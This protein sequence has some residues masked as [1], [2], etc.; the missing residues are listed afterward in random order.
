MNTNRETDPW[1]KLLA[2]KLSEQ[3]TRATRLRRYVTG[4]APMPS[5]GPNLESEWNRFRRTALTNSGGLVVDALAERIVATGATLEGE[6]HV[7]LRRI[8]RDNRLDVTITDAIRDALTTGVGY[9]SISRGE[10]GR[11]VILRERPEQV[12]VIPDPEK[13]WC[14]LAAMKA[15]R[16]SVQNVEYARVW[17][18]GMEYSYMRRSQDAMVMDLAEGW[19]P[20]AVVPLEGRIPIVRL[21][22]LD[23]AGEFEAHLHVIDRINW[24]IL[25]RL[26]TTAMQ[27]FRQRA[28][29]V[30]RDG[31]MLQETDEDGN[32]I[33]YR[34]L[35]KPG[36]GALWELPPGVSLWESQPTDLTPMLTAIKDDFRQLAAVTRTPVTMLIPESANQSAE[37]AAAAREGLV[38]KARDRIARFR[39][40]ISVALVYAMELEGLPVEGT[41]DT[42]FEPPA[43]VTLAERYDAAIKAK[44]AGE[45]LESIQ[46]NI[47]GYSPE[48]IQADRVLRA[49]EQIA[50]AM[51]RTT[52]LPQPAPVGEQP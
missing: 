34:K 50:L 27:A 44:S 48:Q 32:S 23:G 2:G 15:W 46:R 26:V 36:P 8:W 18:D 40:A 14:P 4:D 1:L 31:E 35:F 29:T 38:F 52:P 41:V 19:E 25:Q 51:G 11:A 13:P 39:P 24:G 6:T 43:M 22:N 16:S 9:L 47:L 33:D 42:V 28:L 49:R 7:E 21:E 10:D 12:V 45:S 3:S 17:A 5:M 20:T 30:D 37:G